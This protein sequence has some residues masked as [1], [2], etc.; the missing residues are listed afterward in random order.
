MNIVDREL[1]YKK[2]IMTMTRG[3]NLNL[4]ALP[5]YTDPTEIPV[6]FVETSESVKADTVALTVSAAD[7]CCRT[8]VAFVAFVPADPPVASVDKLSPRPLDV[9]GDLSLIHI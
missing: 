3:D 4:E 7:V 9:L 1:F 5:S 2:D 6:D 8:S